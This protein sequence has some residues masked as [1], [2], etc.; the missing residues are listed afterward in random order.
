MMTTRT[1]FAFS[2]LVALLLMAGT[3]APAQAQF[4]VAAGLNFESVDDIETSTQNNATIDNATGYHVGVVYDLGLGPLN[5]RPGLFYRDLG[6]EFEFPDSRGDVA[7]WEV[8][9][10]V[11]VSV[12]P[13]PLVNPYILGGPKAS[14]YRSDVDEFDD[15]LEEVTY[16][17]TLGV[18]ASLS[19]G[20][21]LT[22]QPELRYDF[23]ATDYVSDD[24]EIGGTEFSPEDPK[25]SSFA[26]RLNVLF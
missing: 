3:A 14:F 9:V 18:G 17:F 25:L 13:L 15:A 6:T 5:L 2:T 7:A 24:F 21:T 1:S 19:V 4:G 16:S 12:L 11:R 20:S 23:G 22:L 10:D 8:P 26:L